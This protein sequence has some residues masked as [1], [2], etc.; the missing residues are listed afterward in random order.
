MCH[1]FRIKA[2]ELLVVHDDLEMVFGEVGFKKGGGLGGHNGLRSVANKMNTRDFH[3]LRL[4]IG[5][6][7]HGSVSAHV[8]GK[9]TQDDQ[10]VLSMLLEKTNQLLQDALPDGI[11]KMEKRYSK[12]KLIN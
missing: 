8:L 5:R 4:G 1:F 10:I 6:P 7:V 9:F 3:R 2:E 11:A 12:I